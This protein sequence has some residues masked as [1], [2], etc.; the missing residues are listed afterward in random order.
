VTWR[1]CTFSFVALINKIDARCIHINVWDFDGSHAAGTNKYWQW[2]CP[3][4]T[5]DAKPIKRHPD[6]IFIREKCKTLHGASP[7]VALFFPRHV[8]ASSRR[9][10]S[11]ETFWKTAP[12][13]SPST[14][15]HP[16]R[17]IYIYFARIV[18]HSGGCKW[19]VLSRN[20]LIS[21]GALA[22][23]WA[24]DVVDRMQYIAW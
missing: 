20:V 4:V 23:T 22:V 21:N 13:H 19:H 12:L 15:P 11:F 17:A 9:H 5:G 1:C 8:F 2:I 16:I 18:T 14:S 10:A 24:S 3:R 6:N 7:L